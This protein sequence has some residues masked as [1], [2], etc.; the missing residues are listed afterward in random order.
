MDNLNKEKFD[1]EKFNNIDTNNF[2][3]SH[4]KIA[5]NHLANFLSQNSYTNEGQ[6][7]ISKPVNN[8]YSTELDYTP[9]SNPTIL[10]DHPDCDLNSVMHD[11]LSAHPEES[12][13]FLNEGK[14]RKKVSILQEHFLPEMKERRIIYAM[15]ANPRRRILEILAEEGIDGFDCASAHEADEALH[16]V[17]GSEAFFNHPIK[18]L[19]A[20]K[21]AYQKG[22]RYFTAQ[23]KE[24][25]EKILQGTLPANFN[26]LSEVVVRLQT[27]N[28]KAKINL[29]TKYGATE[30]DARQMLR[31]LRDDVKNVLAGLSMNTGSQNSSPATFE[32]GIEY[33]ANIARDEG[34]VNSINL[35]GGIPVNYFDEDHFDTRE[36]LQRISQSVR[37]NI[38]GVF[39]YDAHDPKIIIEPGRSII[40]DAVDLA[41][42]VLEI[43]KRGGKPCAYINDGVFCS[44][45]DVAVHGWEYNFDVFS[46]DGRK[47]SNSKKPYVVYGNTCDSGD[48][49]GEV[50]LP[51][52]LK[53]GDFLHVRNAGAYLDSQAS[54]FNGFN[55]PEY[56][57]YNI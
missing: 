38:K 46:K 26:D 33:M 52:N 15:K 18:T 7:L 4:Q 35:G 25:I 42:P 21:G 44:F 8:T 1:P 45:S 54:R 49:L 51:D 34:G 57:S 53:T 23:T 32:K 39:H 11:V 12:F 9:A 40:A 6:W 17:S 37:D 13:C 3:K 56:V 30:E 20:I 24:G 43:E 36:F 28:K 31:F 29:S 22:V 27:L 5:P 19:Q 41:I 55:P 16:Y 10:S 2:S 47:I 50:L 14:L 48:T